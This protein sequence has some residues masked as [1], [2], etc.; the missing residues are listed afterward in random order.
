MLSKYEMRLKPNAELSYEPQ[1]PLTSKATDRQ[2]QTSSRE[3][4]LQLKQVTVWSILD[5]P[6]IAKARSGE[7]N[8]GGRNVLSAICASCNRKEC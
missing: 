6:H 3:R 1:P 2:E 4:P 8:G 5:D 7:T